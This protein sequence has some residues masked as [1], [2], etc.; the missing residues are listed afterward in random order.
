MLCTDCTHYKYGWC[1]MPVPAWVENAIINSA[2]YVYHKPKTA[3][4]CIYYRLP[5]KEE[6]VGEEQGGIHGQEA[7]DC[8]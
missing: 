7:G 6:S 4:R 8:S 1:S 2:G 3:A 5:Q